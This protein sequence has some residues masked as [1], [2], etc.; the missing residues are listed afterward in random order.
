MG[1]QQSVV[2]LLFTV[3]GCP[4]KINKWLR[5]PRDEKIWE[6]L[7]YSVYIVSGISLRLSK[8]SGKTAAQYISFS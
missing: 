4:Q 7:L 1:S 2:Y 3:F 8:P 6:S 5:G